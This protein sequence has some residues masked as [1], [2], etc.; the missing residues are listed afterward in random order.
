MELIQREAKTASS[1]LENVAR[2]EKV[3]RLFSLGKSRY[4]AKDKQRFCRGYLSSKKKKKNTTHKKLRNRW[5]KSIKTS[6]S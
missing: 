6:I 2:K 3:L 1:G 4:E 5:E